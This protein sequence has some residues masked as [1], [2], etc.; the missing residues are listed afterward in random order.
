[1]TQPIQLIA[2]IYAVEAPEHLLQQEYLF[3][4]SIFRMLKGSKGDDEL[5][6]VGIMK[7][8][9]SG[10]DKVIVKLPEPGNW[11]LICTTKECTEEIAKSI[12]DAHGKHFRD[13]SRDFYGIPLTVFTAPESLETLLTS[14][15]LDPVNKNYIILKKVS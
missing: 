12:V 1:M 8:C 4:R 11:Q 2:E 5:V 14:K 13:Y 9:G 3:E 6:I 10:F 15:G 7:R